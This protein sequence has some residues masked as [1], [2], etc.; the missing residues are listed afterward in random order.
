MLKE[1]EAEWE[2]D[3]R[4]L[5]RDAVEKT[6]IFDRVV[7]GLRAD[8]AKCEDEFA[9]RE[10]AGKRVNEAQCE[11]LRQEVLQAEDDV[12]KKNVVI[13]T[14]KA[15]ISTLREKLCENRDVTNKALMSAKDCVTSAGKKALDQYKEWKCQQ[16]TQWPLDKL[17]FS[18]LQ[19]ILHTIE[20]RCTRLLVDAQKR[21]PE[22]GKP[23]AAAPVPSVKNKWLNLFL[24]DSLVSESAAATYL[25]RVVDRSCRHD[26]KVLSN[27]QVDDT[28]TKTSRLSKAGSTSRTYDPGKYNAQSESTGKVVAGTA[29]WN[30]RRKNLGLGL[31]N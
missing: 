15:E 25:D 10:E 8:F 20:M 18:R 9:L 14:L 4:E 1:K 3:R 30:D 26:E 17:Y 28:N 5:G 29:K 23:A 13:S 7:A 11:T 27:Y 24:D 31:E 16:K 19:D 2:V 6:R 12:R 21:F 22:A